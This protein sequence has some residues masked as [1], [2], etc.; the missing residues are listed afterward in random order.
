MV[1]PGDPPSYG[2]PV[3]PTAFPPSLL[4]DDEDLVLGLRPHWMALIVPILQTV[5]IV[6]ALVVGFLYM[7]YSWGGWVFALLLTAALV[8]LLNWPTRLV[9]AWATS[10]FVVTTD[11]VIRRSGLIAKQSIEISLERI[12]DVRFHQTI[13]ERLLGAGD[14]TIE[15]AAGPLTFEDISDPERVQKVIFERKEANEHRK[16]EASARAA[17]GAFWQPGSVAD[18]LDKLHRLRATEIISEEEYR[19]L[20]TRLLERVRAL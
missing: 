14:L 19:E 12:S 11:R 16:E 9:V 6:G 1:A 5:G 7:P 4:A 13:L 2:Q 8:T 17:R 3:N 18:E 15:S 10:R 20:R